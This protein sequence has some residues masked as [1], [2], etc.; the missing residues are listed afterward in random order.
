LFDTV[1]LSVKGVNINEN[2]LNQYNPKVVT[3][4]DKATGALNTKYTIHDEK[5]PFINYTDGYRTL[6]IQVSIPNFLY[7]NNVTLLTEADIPKFFDGLQERIFQLFSINIEHNE[8]ITKRCDISCNFQVGNKVS[9][10]IQHLSKQ[11]LPFKNTHSYNHDQTVEF[12]N[13]SSR[14]IFYDKSKQMEKM[15][16]PTEIIEQA[17]GILRLEVKPSYND[18]KKFSTYRMANELLNK[19]FFEYMTGKVIEELK[20]PVDA[21]SM[22]LTWLLENT[23][24]ISKIETL[25]GFQLLQSMFDETTLKEVYTI[26]TLAN[27]KSLAKIITFPVRNCLSPLVI[28]YAN[29]S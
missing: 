27:R 19:A 13:K 18:M 8:W 17:K 15:K 21:S 22:N 4:L 5:I 16:K 23:T 3:F 6:N 7:G 9:E 25:L 24:N 14:I 29:I 28:D 2:M 1:V 20:Y 26:G 12:S 11:K 10:Y